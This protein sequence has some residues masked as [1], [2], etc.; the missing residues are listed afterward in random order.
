[1]QMRI[2]KLNDTIGLEQMRSRLTKKGSSSCSAISFYL[3]G[4][5]KAITLYHEVDNQYPKFKASGNFCEEPSTPKDHKKIVLPSQIEPNQLVSRPHEWRRQRFS[6][7]RLHHVLGTRPEYRQNHNK[8]VR[9]P[10][11]QQSIH[12]A[13]F[14]IL[15]GGNIY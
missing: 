15:L 6:R 14:D 11:R 13:G 3:C 7:S 8:P 5:T 12:T 9:P 4:N 10:E 2:A 1:M